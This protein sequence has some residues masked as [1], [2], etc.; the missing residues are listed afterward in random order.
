MASEKKSALERIRERLAEDESGCWIWQGPTDVKGYPKF[1]S[2]HAYRAL[3]LEMVGPVPEGLELDH[4]CRKPLCCNPD[5][6]EPV[7]HEENQRRR[8]TTVCRRGHPR[9]QE[10]TRI[11]KKPGLVDGFQV[12]IPCQRIGQQR[13]R[14]AARNAR[15]SAETTG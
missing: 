2:Q 4:L 13:Y 5:H 12:C 10:N 9:N 1:G 15:R 6:L 7:T 14:D 11:Q 8:R 3:Y